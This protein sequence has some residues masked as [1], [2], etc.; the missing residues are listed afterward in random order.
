MVSVDAL[1]R[2]MGVRDYLVAGLHPSKDAGYTSFTERAP[3][4]LRP[5]QIRAT[6]WRG[7]HSAGQI[8]P[9]NPSSPVRA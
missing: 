2:G 3:L 4:R 6:E 7:R 1:R 9:P 8:I 5:V